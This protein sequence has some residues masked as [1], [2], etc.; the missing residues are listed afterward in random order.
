MVN[1]LLSYSIKIVVVLNLVFVCT[2]AWAQQQNVEG[3]RVEPLAVT[4][5]TLVSFV[6]LQDR[7]N[8]EIEKVGKQIESSHSDLQTAA[9]KKQLDKLRQEQQTT[10]QNFKEIAAGVDISS[11]SEA[12]EPAFNLQEEFLAL[13]KPAFEEVKELT[14]Q[15][16][17]KTELKE[18]LAYARARL[19]IIEQALANIDR[20]KAEN[21]NQQL[22]QSLEKVADGWRNQQSFLQSEEQAAQ[23]KLDKLLAAQTS[24]TESSQSYLKRFFKKRGLYLAEA[25]IAVL[26]VVGLSRLVYNAMKRLMPGFRAKHRSF[27]VRLAQLAHRILTVLFMVLGP[28]VVFYIAEDWVLFSLGILI[29]FGLAWTLRH[30][31]PRYWQQIYLFLNI[32]SVRE[33]ERILIEGLPWQVDDINFFTSLVNPTAGLRQRV[34]I[35]DLVDQKSRPYSPKE[36]WFPCSEGD[37]VLL[38]DNVR[39]KVTGIAPE[40][41]QLI[42]RGGAKYT[43]QISEFLANSPRNLS[44]NFRIKEVLGI[45]YGLQAQA[46][47]EIPEILHQFILSR[48]NQDGYGEQ[49]LNLRVEFAMANSSSLDLMVVADFD[50]SLAPLYNRVRRA[51][52]RW[53]VEACTEN[54]WE[55]PFPQMTLHQGA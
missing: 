7:L 19:P 53:C 55:I 38:K 13:L 12:E 1:R 47:N 44:T 25:L 40:M 2:Q 5:E 39:G 51:I 20:L 22:N 52:Q 15:A 26:F 50:G 31:L 4:L 23:L 18:K 45:S 6:E 11:L 27:R 16:R 21:N 43:Y 9:L 14:S 32:G 37:W 24:F 34:P 54:G 28:M 30:A 17:L 42:E 33:G 48:A 8:Q 35:G 10:N 29:L 41:V 49:L 36:P 3:G 46:T